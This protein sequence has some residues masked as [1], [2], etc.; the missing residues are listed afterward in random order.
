MK[1]V[2]VQVMRIEDLVRES[3]DAEL[4]EQVNV[5]REELHALEAQYDH[6]LEGLDVLGEL[7]DE[8][9]VILRVVR[10][11][12]ECELT[13]PEDFTK[14]VQQYIHKWSATNRLRRSLDRM[15]EQNLTDV[16]AQAMLENNLPPQFIYVALQESGFENQAVE[17]TTGF[18]IAKGMWQFIPSTARRYGLRTR[19]LVELPV[20]DPMDDRFKPEAAA[21]AA[22]HYLRD[23]Y[24]KDAGFQP[25]RDGLIQLGP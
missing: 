17:P 14:I 12:G 23:I 24:S 25:S 15:E 3:G 2:Q 4:I 5:R 21:R 20:Q 9:R 10:M 16:F 22:A 18:G 8:D 11:L 6:F 1:A 13:V 19:P 7:S